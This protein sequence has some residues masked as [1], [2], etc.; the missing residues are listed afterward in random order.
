[1]SKFQQRAR[2]VPNPVRVEVWRK[3][4]LQISNPALLLHNFLLVSRSSVREMPGAFSFQCT[5]IRP[6][7]ISSFCRCCEAVICCLLVHQQLD[8]PCLGSRPLWCCEARH[9]PFPLVASVVSCRLSQS[10][11]GLSSCCWCVSPS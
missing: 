8:G 11:H 2:A 3:F 10:F 7:C 9:P 4:S 5:R 1:M 6:R